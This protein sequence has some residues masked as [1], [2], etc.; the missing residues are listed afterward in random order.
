MTIV[1]P[2]RTVIETSSSTGSVNARLTWSRCTT[3]G[4]SGA[5]GV[6]AATADAAAAESVASE[7][8]SSSRIA[9]RTRV[10]LPSSSGDASSADPLVTAE[11]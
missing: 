11:C 6:P 1:C 10:A 5:V 7:A 8:S 2:S 9:S 3:G 4:L